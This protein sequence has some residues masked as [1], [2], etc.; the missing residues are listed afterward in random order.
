MT[1]AV[2]DDEAHIRESIAQYIHILYP[3]EEV[4]MLPDAQS[5]LAL[6]QPIDILF[7]DIQMQPVSGM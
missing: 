6:T 3:N 2:C 1:I 5:L 7:L 4:V